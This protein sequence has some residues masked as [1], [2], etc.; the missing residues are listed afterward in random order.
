[1]V[2]AC[3]SVSEGG[4]FGNSGPGGVTNFYI[5]PS[6]S[7]PV[8]ETNGQIVWRGPSQTVTVTCYK[9]AVHYPSLKMNENKF[10]FGRVKQETHLY[11]IFQV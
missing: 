1:M 5:D 11:Q 10:I 7:V 9:D 8:D 6:A 2:L 3:Y 4:I